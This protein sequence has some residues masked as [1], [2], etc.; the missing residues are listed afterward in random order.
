MIVGRGML[1]S[2]FRTY[3]NNERVL[4]FASGVSNSRE[5]TSTAFEREFNLIKHTI[6]IHPDKLF[7]YFST[8]SMYDPDAK[9]TPYVKHKMEMES[10]IKQN[11]KEFLIL[12]VSQILGKSQSTTLVNFLLDCI[13]N[14]KHF[15]L[16][17]NSNRNLIA[18]DDVVSIAKKLIDKPVHHNSVYHI[19]NRNYIDVLDLVQLL[20]NLNN[21]KANYFLVEKGEKYS[22][23][24]TEAVVDK[25]INDLEIR[26]DNEYYIKKIRQVFDE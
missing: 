1:A 11:T 18:L 17:E 5:T 19:A 14:N 10:Y 26:F 24:P 6:N 12:R 25:I 23:I 20:E 3:N 15:E 4:I 9:E 13:E 8:C 7:V 21:K 16:W 2:A 22:T